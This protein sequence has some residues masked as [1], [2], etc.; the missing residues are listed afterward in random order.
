MGAISEHIE[1]MNRAEQYILNCIQEAK[2]RGLKGIPFNP[3]PIWYSKET[4]LRLEHRGYKFKAENNNIII[5][6]D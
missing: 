1:P 3:Q 4:Q 2:D 5:Y 6:W